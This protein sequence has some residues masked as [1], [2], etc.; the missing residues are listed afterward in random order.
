MEG[1]H[2]REELD[3]AKMNG[4]LRFNVDLFI[5]ALEWV[6]SV[7]TCLGCLFGKGM[8]YKKLSFFKHRV[9]LIV[10]DL[11][12]QK[13]KYIAPMTNILHPCQFLIRSSVF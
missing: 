3:M 5:S 1:Q 10:T 8:H 4:L 11:G 9:G 2:F 7:D 13:F 6:P 12:S